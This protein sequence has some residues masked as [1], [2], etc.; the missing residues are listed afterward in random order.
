[1]FTLKELG[2]KYHATYYHHI[3]LTCLW[4]SATSWSVSLIHKTQESH[5]AHP[6]K[7]LT[8][9]IATGSMTH[10][11]YV[12]VGHLNTIGVYNFILNVL[13][14]VLDIITSI[15]LEWP[16]SVITILKYSL[17]SLTPP[18]CLLFAFLFTSP[19]L[20]LRMCEACTQWWYG[21]FFYRR[22]VALG[23]SR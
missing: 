11:C 7:P 21:N 18:L 22:A 6:T 20:S 12:T 3:T 19:S 16:Q 10:S 1:M 2:I 23:A 13:R 4:L 17:L 15:H 8:D 9:W 5:N 14:Y